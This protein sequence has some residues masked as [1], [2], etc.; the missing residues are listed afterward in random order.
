MPDRTTLRPSGAAGSNCSEP[1]CRSRSPRA[2]R[3]APALPLMAAAAS[4]AGSIPTP[5]CARSR[6]GPPRSSASPRTP[7]RC[8]RQVRRRARLRPVAVR[9]RQPRAV[10]AE[11]GPHRIR[12]QVMN[13]FPSRSTL[14]ACGVLSPPWRSCASPRPARRS[15][16]SPGPAGA[17]ADDRRRPDTVLTD[18][19]AARA[20]GQD[21]LRRQRDP[22]RSAREGHRRRL[23]HA[24]IV[25]GFVLAPT[26]SARN[27]T[28]PK[29]RSR[30]RRTCARRKRS[31]RGRKRCRSCPPRRHFG[32][33]V[34]VA[35]QRRRRH[36]RAGQAGQAQARP[37][38]LDVTCSSC[39][40]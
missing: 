15:R 24:T 5:R 34:A 4:A 1:G 20:P 35:A 28:S 25:P 2:V 30:S 31:I 7:A 14:P 18:G 17:G 11:Q 39:C 27:A 9:Q 29:A 38:G 12:G 32:G 33:A 6:C 13:R 26:R 23:R 3:A 10:G 40:R 8:S 36:R 37:A 16:R 19:A 21:R 22:R